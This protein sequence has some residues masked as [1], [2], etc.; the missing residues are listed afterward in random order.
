R[1][2][3]SFA[4]VRRRQDVRGVAQGVA[5]IDDFAHHPTAVRETLQALKKRY[6]RGKL[7]AIYEPRSA[8]GRRATFQKEFGQ[9]FID[10]GAD[11]VV[12][13]QL[14]DPSRI[15]EAERF[16]PERLAA[17]VRGRGIPARVAPDGTAIVEHVAQR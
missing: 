10:G 13:A 9:A 8:T 7:L 2:I 16:D 14:H 4:G 12:V 11:E 15:P 17:D 3:R 1:G 5:V 6:G